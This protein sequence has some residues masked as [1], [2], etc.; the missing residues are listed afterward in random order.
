MEIASCFL[1]RPDQA[2]TLLVEMRTLALAHNDAANARGCLSGI[3][4]SAHSLKRYGLAYRC[5]VRVMREAPHLPTFVAAV[6]MFEEDM[7][8]M[9]LASGAY[10]R[11][12]RFGARAIKH[13]TIAGERSGADNSQEIARIALRL[14]QIQ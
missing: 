14:S 8:T 7:M 5:H 1:S 10:P 13:Y 2:L 12:S 4:R 11:A 6:A 9:S 3:G